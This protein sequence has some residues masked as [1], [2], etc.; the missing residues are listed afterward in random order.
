MKQLSETLERFNR[1]ERCLLVRAVLGDNE[2]KLLLDKAFLKEVATELNITPIDQKTAWWATDYHYDWLAGAL[3]IHIEGEEGEIHKPRTNLSATSEPPKQRYLVEGN[4]ED[5]DLVIASGSDLILIEA[6]AYGA[7][8]NK[9][10]TSKL[11]RLE[12]LH[13]ELVS[14]ND[15]IKPENELRLHLLLCSPKKPE[16]LHPWP[17][18][19]K[20]RSDIPWIKLELP[21]EG[22]TILD[23]SRCNKEGTEM[24]S[25]Q[26]W[27]IG[28]VKASQ[29]A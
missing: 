29:H 2:K 13:Q 21:P 3:A 7:W 5:A 26:F 25:G 23:V 28:E 10:M 17:D 19:L 27:H 12:L 14:L 16:K 11:A 22:D 9:Q 4:Q 24:A 1:K 15:K 20:R 6:K 18:W 8:T